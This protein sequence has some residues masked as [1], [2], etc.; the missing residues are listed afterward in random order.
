MIRSRPPFATGFQVTDQFS[1]LLEFI[2]FYSRQTFQMAVSY[3]LAMQ[4]KTL[5]FC[6]VRQPQLAGSF[7]ISTAA[8]MTHLTGYWSGCREALDAPFNIRFWEDRIKGNF[9]P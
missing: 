2:F 3:R 7:Q 5:E 1:F 4:Q 6:S 8:R 9:G